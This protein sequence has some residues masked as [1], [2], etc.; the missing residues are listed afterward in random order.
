[1]RRLFV[2][3]VP[4][5]VNVEITQILLS[6]DLRSLISDVTQNDL[7]SIKPINNGNLTGFAICPRNLYSQDLN[8]EFEFFNSDIQ[9]LNSK[10]LIHGQKMAIVNNKIVYKYK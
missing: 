2:P 10:F 7:F 3:D 8:L 5:Y 9:H 6:R 1:M 4:A